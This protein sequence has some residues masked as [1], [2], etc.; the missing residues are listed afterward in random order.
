[1]VT[2]TRLMLEIDAEHPEGPQRLAHFFQR[3]SK[4]AGQLR[5]GMTGHDVLLRYEP[6]RLSLQCATCGYESPGWDL[7]PARALA[8]RRALD[9]E[10]VLEPERGRRSRPAARIGTPVPA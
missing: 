2:N 10:P 5:C 4:R 7:E 3:A 6:T 9:A 1:M 8:S